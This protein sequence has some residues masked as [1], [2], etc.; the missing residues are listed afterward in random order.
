VKN[1]SKL[2]RLLLFGLFVV[3]FVFI[4][5]SIS[6]SFVA[7]GKKWASSNIPVS[8]YINPADSSISSSDFINAVNIGKQKWNDVSNIDFAFSYKGETNLGLDLYDGYNVWLW[9]P[10]GSGMSS[11]T[12]AVTQFLYYQDTLELVACDVEFNGTHSWTWEETSSSPYDVQSVATHEA[13]HWLWLDHSDTTDSVMYP[14]YTGLRELGQ[15]DID[16]I[17][18]LYGDYTPT[19]T[20]TDTDTPTPTPTETGGGDGGGGGG[21]GC[22]IATAAY[23]SYMDD[24]VM[25]LRHFRDDVL[26]K[27]AAGRSFVNFYYKNSPPV[28]NVIAKDDT[29]RF[30]ARVILTPV[31]YAVAYPLQTLL[32]LFALVYLVFS[33]KKRIKKARA[34]N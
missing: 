7:D 11:G 12:L 24:H 3:A 14:T 27:S 22:F 6:N 28:A 20:P 4:A 32:V 18:Y 16:G 34:T 17:S 33:V 19:P 23:G 5:I 1:R 9:N 8:Y 13:G 31:V 29:L 10:T 21:G 15:D 25:Q 2:Q 30:G 26:M